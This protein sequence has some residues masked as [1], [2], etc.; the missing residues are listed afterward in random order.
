MFILFSNYV[1]YFENEIWSIKNCNSFS[2]FNSD[3]ST[4]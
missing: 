2:Y 3:I 4:I 1:K